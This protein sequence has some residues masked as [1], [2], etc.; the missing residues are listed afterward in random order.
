MRLLI[1]VDDSIHSQRAVRFVAGMRWPAGSRM[2]VVS[3][4]HA[5]LPAAAA[6]LSGVGAELTEALQALRHRHESLIAS[7]QRRLRQAGHSAEGRVLEGDAREQLI[8]IA[9]SERADLLVLGSRG[10]HGIA[11]LMLGSVSAHSASHAPCSVLVVKQHRA[12]ATRR[13][14]TQSQGG[15]P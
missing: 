2:L 3:V 1:A 5:P 10:R 15:R 14:H 9:E 7:V 11:R 13:R 4:M 12:A 8:A 6:A